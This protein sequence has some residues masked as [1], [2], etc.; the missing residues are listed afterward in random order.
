MYTRILQSFSLLIPAA[1]F[2]SSASFQSTFSGLLNYVP[3]IHVFFINN[4]YYLD[5]KEKI[6]CYF[7]MSISTVFHVDFRGTQHL[8][9]I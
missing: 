1:C 7:S 5:T 9:S 3:A 4:R 2:I 8:N 6:H